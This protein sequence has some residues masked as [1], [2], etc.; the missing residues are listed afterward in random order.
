MAQKDIADVAEAKP[1]FPLAVVPAKPLEQRRLKLIAASASDIG[2]HWGAVLTT[3]TPFAATLQPEF[4]SNHASQLRPGDQIDI[5]SDGR[6]FYGRL[7]VRDA[8][9]LRAFVGKIE[10]VEF[11]ALASSTEAATHRVK[12][13][14]PHLKW[15]IERIADGK[16]IKDGL[17]QEAAEQ[18]LKAIE[19]SL[20][21]VA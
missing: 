2:N 6:E 8:T 1:G 12:Y 10:F 17:E 11:N 9:K 5:H 20:A 18:A 14:G 21:K 13:G 3:G 16:V 15:V 7:Y 4:W 19:R